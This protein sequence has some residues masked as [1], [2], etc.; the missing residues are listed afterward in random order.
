MSHLTGWQGERTGVWEHNLPG[1]PE[2]SAL[3]AAHQARPFLRDLLQMRFCPLISL[4]QLQEAWGLAGCPRLMGF[5]C[6]LCKTGEPS[7][8]CF[9]QKKKGR[10]KWS[11]HSADTEWAQGCCSQPSVWIMEI[12]FPWEILDTYNLCRFG[13]ETSILIGEESTCVNK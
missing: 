1:K 4:S 9:S 12:L 10:T 7:A 2:A 8:P 11:E 3:W 5:P 13:E 6:E